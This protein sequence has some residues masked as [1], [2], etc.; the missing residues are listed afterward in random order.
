M[1]I[2]FIPI[3]DA[4]ALLCVDLEIDRAMHCAT[5]RNFS[6]LDSRKNPIELPLADA[7]AIVN[8]RDG[9]GPVVKV[10]RLTFVHKHRRYGR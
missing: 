7:K 1:A 6:R 3:N 2:G 9:I 5:V 10:D 8:Q 4:A